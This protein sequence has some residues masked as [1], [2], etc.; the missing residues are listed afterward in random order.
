MW[1]NGRTLSAL[2]LPGGRVRVVGGAPGGCAWG[3]GSDPPDEFVVVGQFES[4][5]HGGK[6]ASAF[7]AMPVMIASKISMT[8]KRMAMSRAKQRR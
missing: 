8:S 2:C 5:I 7:H 3:G 4:D 6:G 1:K